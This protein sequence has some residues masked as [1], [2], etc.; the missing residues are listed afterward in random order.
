MGI[1]RVGRLDSCLH[2]VTEKYLEL[3]HVTQRIKGSLTWVI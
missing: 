3:V 1:F 2:I